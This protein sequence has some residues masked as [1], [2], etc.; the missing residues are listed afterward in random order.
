MIYMT[1][2]G[3]VIE[4]NDNATTNNTLSKR[5]GRPSSM[6]DVNTLLNLYQKYTST[7][8]AKMYDVEPSTVRSWYSRLRKELS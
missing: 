4:V 3:R 7:E 6:P 5:R 8:I 1:T 2:D